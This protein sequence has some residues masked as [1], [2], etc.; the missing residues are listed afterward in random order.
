MH[1]DPLRP[2]PSLVVA[3]VLSL[4]L[5][6]SGGRTA[7]SP[8]SAA[9]GTPQQSRTGSTNTGSD[10]PA[11]TGKSKPGDQVVTAQNVELRPDALEL[12]GQYVGLDVSPQGF[13][14]IAA[15]H[16]RD[17]LKLDVAKGIQAPPKDS[18]AT[19]AALRFMTRWPQEPLLPGVSLERRAA[20]IAAMEHIPVN[21][22]NGAAARA[23]LHAY[24]WGDYDKLRAAEVRKAL[25]DR[26]IE[27]LVATLP[28]P[29]DSNSRWMFD[30]MIDALQRA[31]SQSRFVLDS[32]DFR[33]WAPEHLRPEDH[34]TEPRGVPKQW[35]G[36][37]LFRDPT[38]GPT[39]PSRLLVVFCVAETATSG[40]HM[41]SLRRSLNVIRDLTKDV[42]DAPPIRILGPTFSGSVR[43]LVRVLGDFEARSE[44]PP[45]YR[46]ISGAA[47][48]NTLAATIKAQV[49]NRATYHATVLPDTFVLPRLK[50]YL[51]S[52]HGSEGHKTAVLYEGNTGYGSGLVDLINLISPAMRLPFPLHISRLR[53]SFNAGDNREAST[54]GA[55][56]RFHALPLAE[57]G[58]ATD[59][60]PAMSPDITASSVELMLANMMDTLRR[61]RVRTIW[62]LATDARDKLFLA[63]QVA[64]TIPDVTIVTTDAD[65]LFVHSDFNRYVRGMVVAS[66]YPLM[67]ESQALVGNPRDRTLRNQFS[68]SD[69]EGTYNAAI[70][71]LNY[72]GN[73]RPLV[74][75]DD[76]GREIPP[77]LLLDYQSDESCS[78]GHCMPQ[79]WITVV[80]R[81]GLW[82]VVSFTPTTNVLR[83]THVLQMTPQNA[84]SA[85]SAHV[86]APSEPV[87]F[88]LAVWAVIALVTV[89]AFV[90]ARTRSLFERTRALPY[91]DMFHA[92]AATRMYEFVILFALTSLGVF[93]AIVS[94]LALQLQAELTFW[95]I[96]VYWITLASEGVAGACLAFCAIEGAW[97]TVKN[98]RRRRPVLFGWADPSPGGRGTVRDQARLGLL[99]LGAT[100]AIGSALFLHQYAWPFAQDSSEKWIRSFV[101]LTH[102]SNGLSPLLP[103][104]CVTSA[105]YIWAA[106]HLRRL[107]DSELRLTV[108][109]RLLTDTIILRNPATW[110]QR[111]TGVLHGPTQGLPQWQVAAV[112]AVMAVNVAFVLSC[113]P[114]TL[115][116]INYSRFF[117]FAWMMVQLVTV[118]SIVQVVCLWRLSHTFLAAVS[119]HPF[120]PAFRRIAS[121][122][123]FASHRFS[124]KAPSTEDF[125]PLVE[126]R[127]ML[128]AGLPALRTA[129]ALVPARGQAVAD[130]RFAP[131]DL[132]ALAVLQEPTA[133]ERHDDVD[134]RWTA[135][136]TW[137][138]LL[139]ETTLLLNVL[140]TFWQEAP[141]VTFEEERL[142][143]DP[144]RK[145]HRHAEELIAM[146]LTIVIRELLSRVMSY[147]MLILALL[148]LM[149]T[150][151]SSFPI[152]PKQPLLALTWVYVATGIAVGLMIVVLMERDPILSRL[153]GTKPNRVTWDMDF[154]WK[155]TLYGLVPLLTLF[156]A[157]FPDVGNTLLRWLAP[158]KP[159]P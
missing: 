15:E 107:G 108:G 43:T 28:D 114:V 42:K 143:F 40:I 150:A 112:W 96:S 92:T 132:D 46:I 37:V 35:P 102:P 148:V 119:N 146:E 74:Y 59:Q 38:P 103:A 138:S 149:V 7:Y 158:I 83:N 45:T 48:S 20:L 51:L 69:A 6:A 97:A 126:Q 78:I 54:I 104:V 61:N 71:L 77:P 32:F 86:I 133:F 44:K 17:L 145:W 5:L 137:T 117:V 118:V 90:A 36:V 2:L 156:A 111:M 105:L 82:P 58:A 151:L 18:D 101:R 110:Q 130:A 127:R 24:F 79:L 115:E 25:G 157:Q 1:S 85:L 47:T 87:L 152:Q 11:T 67:M 68:S 76:E 29:I 80:G 100:L 9:R 147:L 136:G 4:T 153:S 94:W 144:V 19:T 134:T 95:S 135:T 125:A 53:A 113:A 39:K 56:P 81:D 155:L 154:I 49:G 23:F 141:G 99:A 60:L 14:K 52:T 12:L 73:G 64:E 3:G 98:I 140:K 27:F 109:N 89:A 75:H 66:T 30:P 62:L 142:A 41:E 139:A 93:G 22:P 65:L 33:D 88:G 72:D 122:V 26:P 131:A 128:A 10:K 84:K 121:K 50:Q 106:F 31:T 116:R 55:Q 91:F 21:P 124:F 57:T 129:T 159:L 16:I 120:A 63:R 34:P 123:A 70:A 13:Q 8:A